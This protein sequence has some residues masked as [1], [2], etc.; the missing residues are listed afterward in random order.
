MMGVGD[1]VHLCRRAPLERGRTDLAQRGVAPP[2]IIGFLTQMCAGFRAEP[3]ER[4]QDSAGFGVRDPVAQGALVHS[5]TRQG[6][7][8]GS[9]DAVTS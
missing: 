7:S 8:K 2:V 6:W 3:A 9:D 5:A 1:S 4:G